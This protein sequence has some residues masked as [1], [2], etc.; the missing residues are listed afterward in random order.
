MNL[1]N[2]FRRKQF[3]EKVLVFMQDEVT[4]SIYTDL[5][6]SLEGVRYP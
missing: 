4:E 2:F 1:Y 6:E 3:V 5:I